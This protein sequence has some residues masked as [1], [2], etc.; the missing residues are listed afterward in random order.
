MKEIKPLISLFAIGLIAINVFSQVG[1][2]TTSPAASSML[3]ITSSTQGF[4]APR[5]TSAQ[6]I[7]ISAPAKGLMVFDTD[8]NVFYYFDGTSWQPILAA[9]VNQRNNYK[10][11]KSIADLAPELAAGGGSKYLLSTNYFYEINGTISLSYP[12]DL[13]NAYIAGLDA[14]EDRLVRGSGTIFSGNTGGSIRNLTIIAGAGSV[15]SLTGATTE[16]IIIQNSIIANSA[17]VGTISGFGIVFMNIIQFVGNTNGIIFD[18][19]GGN[20]L[21]SNLAWFNNNGGTF[22]TYKG[23]FGLIEKIS[24]FSSVPAGATGINVSFNPTVTSANINS[25]PFTGAGTFVNGY[26]VGSYPG[27]KFSKEWYVECPG[28]ASERDGVAAG[29][30]YVTTPV[31]TAIGTVNTPVKVAGTTTG[32]NLFRT[33][34]LG[35]NNIT[36][37]GAK[38]RYFTY[39]ASISFTA[40][41]NNQIASFYIYKNGVKLPE[42][43]QSR[44]IGTGA[45]VGSI[46]ISG[47]T[48]L[49]SNDYL[50]VWVENDALNNV[51][52]QSMNFIIR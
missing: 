45:D 17:S 15:F 2:G 26:T 11:V 24:G 35:N 51:T 5:M 22:E 42:S 33:T 30:V 29:N 1:I 9:G 43:K 25:T 44:K 12:I 52:A 31:A 34:S 38:T 32:I 10:L 36:Y 49:N 13:N 4:L 46:S 37:T 3:D 7:A 16:T 28:L 20:L 48:Q 40:S 39:N 21:L 50:E 27:Y 14:N 18:G 8:G 19:A 23:V 41:G 47:V 6:R